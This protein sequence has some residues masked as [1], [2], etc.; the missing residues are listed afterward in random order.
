MHCECAKTAF[1]YTPS[2]TFEWRGEPTLVSGPRTPL[3][4]ALSLGR[5]VPA[6]LLHR[7]TQEGE[8]LIDVAA[9]IADHQVQTQSGAFLG[10]QSAVV[11]LAQEARYRLAIEFVVE[12]HR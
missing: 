12:V 2:M 5:N 3:S 8:L 9:G 6:E 4:R 1:R 7:I 10:G 11:P